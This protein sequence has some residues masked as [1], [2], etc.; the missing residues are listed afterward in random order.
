M[1]EPGKRYVTDANGLNAVGRKYSCDHSMEVWKTELWSEEF[2]YG[3]TIS[4]VFWGN[5]MKLA[6]IF[7][8]TSIL[9]MW[10]W[11]SLRIICTC[12]C[13]IS[14]QLPGFRVRNQV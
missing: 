10:H 1:C 9:D 2:L 5:Q 12:N 14:I 11:R 13:R 4:S 7:Y 3:E 6:S 8:K